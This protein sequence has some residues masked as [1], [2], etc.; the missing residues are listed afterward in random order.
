MRTN[1]FAG[2]GVR[3]AGLLIVAGLASL[4]IQPVV[5]SQSGDALP[6]AK[7]FLITGD[8]A[9]GSVDLTPQS[10]GGG[11]LTGTVPMTGVPANAEVL[12]AYVYW[13]TISTNVAQ[14]DG[15]R[16]RGEPMTVVKGS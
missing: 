2:I 14:V 6:F 12:A 4:V 9:V 16:F 10:G 11:F 13:E 1:S 5:H 7:S 8:Y 3:A 15:A